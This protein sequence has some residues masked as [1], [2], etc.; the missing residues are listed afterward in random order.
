MAVQ[1]ESGE[2]DQDEDKGGPVCSE[3]VEVLDLVVE[4]DREGSRGSGNVAAQHEHDA[5]LANRVGEG[6]NSRGEQ[7]WPGER[8]HD[9]AEGPRGRRPKQ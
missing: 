6:E 7:R 9:G 1:R 2:R 5:E 8:K 4:S 3:V